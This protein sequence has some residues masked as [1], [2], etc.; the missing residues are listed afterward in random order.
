MAENNVKRVVIAADP[1]ALATAVADRF[2]TRVVKRVRAG[3][4]VHVSL[5]GGGMGTA[6]LR[7][8]AAHPKASDLDWS[9]VHFW[10][11]DERFVPAGSAER[12][13]VG[14]TEVFFSRLNVPAANIHRMAASDS[15][16]SIDAAAQAYAAELAT[17][18][19]AVDTATGPLAGDWPAFDICFLGVGPDGHIAS[20]FPDRPEI[21]I[22]DRAAVPVLDSPKPPPQRI[23]LTRPVINSS[24]RIWLVLAGLDKASALGL[25]LAGASYH[26][27][28]AAGARGRRRTV[29]FVDEQAA[30]NV[31]PDLIDGSY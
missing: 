11:S 23:T 4:T 2:Y 27:V 1:Q 18:A 8:A 14:A 16:V 21:A 26:S 13:E 5:T 22:T 24:Q 9:N 12:N 19:P 25:A 30:Q 17:F 7:A 15:G 29:F 31:P 3:K 20:L 6:V 10:W 28:P